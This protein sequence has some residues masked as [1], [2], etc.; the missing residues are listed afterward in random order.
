MQLPN[1]ADLVATF[2]T[3]VRIG[4]VATPLPV[5]FREHAPPGG[6]LL[7]VRTP[8]RLSIRVSAWS[9]AG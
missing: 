3:I 5:Q 4:A 6:K 8:N 7:D 9:S 1:I 2:L